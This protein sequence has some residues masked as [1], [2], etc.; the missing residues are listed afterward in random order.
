MATTINLRKL[1]H[2]KQVEM[3]SPCPVGSGIGTF[4]RFL[5]VPAYGIKFGVGVT[6]LNQQWMYSPDEDAWQLLPASASAGTF[7]ACA[8][9]HISPIGPSAT[10]TGGTT[11]TILTALTLNHDLRGYKVRI[12]AGPAAA[13]AELTIL[14]NTLGANA[15]IT[16][17][18]QGAAFTAATTF[19]LLTP[20]FWYFCPSAT[21]PG[22]NVYDWAQNTWTARAVTGLP[23]AW[24]I[25]ARMTGTPGIKGG[26]YES[27]VGKTI[28]T[29]TA[30]TVVTTAGAAWTVNQWAN[31]QIR[32]T[33]GTGAG[34][35]R[36]IASN[37]SNTL[38]VAALTTA[39]DAT[40]TWVIEGNDDA[41]YLLGNNS[42]NLYKYSVA[43]NSWS[44]IAPGVVRAGAPGTACS[45]DWISS[46]SDSDWADTSSIH[47]GRY[48]Y[49]FRGA[50][51]SLLDVYD[52]A[53][54]AWRACFYGNQG[55]GM[56]TGSS[57]EYDADS[58][59]IQQVG[60]RIFRF[61]LITNRLEP[62]HTLSYTNGTA[63]VGDKLF[64]ATYNDGATVLK[65]LY[66]MRNSAT[67]LFRLMLY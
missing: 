56:T 1:L 43:G 29:C 12:T 18:T 13:G 38:T 8:C 33:G 15:A 60:Q 47:N 10:A 25:D 50:G 30:T 63:V 57:Y 26:V 24:T 19:T 59:Y 40:S 32:V 16:V 7:G 64:V 35:I 28:G 39:L 42:V 36:T 65:W 41:I 5:E 27:Q 11:A 44:T 21:A 45:S 66:I 53:L 23:T 17:A 31:S 49:S 52:I 54:N 14:S 9:G 3:C 4:F 22:F 48:I 34:Q 51:G 58:I 46:C 61:N 67:E 62:L 55:E 20:R 37:T 6:A 2:R